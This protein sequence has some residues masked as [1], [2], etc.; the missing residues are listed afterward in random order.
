MCDG[1]IPRRKWEEWEAK[2]Q[3]DAT[4]GRSPK[5]GFSFLFACVFFL[6]MFSVQ[7]SK[8]FISGTVKYQICCYE[9][10]CRRNEGHTLVARTKSFCKIHIC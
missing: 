2:M 6:Y 5:P 10:F 1:G 3:R 8:C 9:L 4:A 7:S